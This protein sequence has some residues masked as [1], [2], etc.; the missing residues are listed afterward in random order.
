MTPKPAP[1]KEFFYEHFIKPQTWITTYNCIDYRLVRDDEKLLIVFQ[2]SRGFDNYNGR[3]D[4]IRNI[5]A[6]WKWTSFFKCF[7]HK[8]YCIAFDNSHLKIFENIIK[9]VI[10]NKI[11][12]IKFVGY[13]Q[14]SPLAILEYKRYLEIKEMGENWLQNVELSEPISFGGPAFIWCLF[15]WR[16]HKYLKNAMLVRTKKDIVPKILKWLGYRHIG[17]VEYLEEPKGFKHPEHIP[18][19]IRATYHYPEYYMACLPSEKEYFNE[20][21]DSNV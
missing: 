13:S 8:G 7:M 5:R 15:S 21:E 20:M 14:G 4:W 16:M 3:K 1:T 18:A 17:K 19:W 9:N 12:Q 6:F 2:Q 10:T 11:K